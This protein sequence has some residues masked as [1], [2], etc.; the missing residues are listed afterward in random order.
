MAGIDLEAV[1]RDY[2]AGMSLRSLALKY[3]CSK[4]AVNKWAKRD[5]WQRGQGGHVDTVHT[6]DVEPPERQPEATADGPYQAL[7]G[8][9]GKV[10]AR[11]DEALGDPK[12]ISARD[13]RGI[14]ATLLDIRQLL[15]AVS[16]LEAEEQ[17]LR[18]QALQRETEQRGA[19]EREV[20][21]RFVDTEGAE[22]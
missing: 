6:E 17:R 10:L 1:R 13:L 12:P 7:A 14:A 11:V 18:L 9:A 22:E 15:N 3:G 8:L 19:A 21:I 5:G 20:T 16:P 2:E 4:S